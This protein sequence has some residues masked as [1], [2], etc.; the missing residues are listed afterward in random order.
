MSGL[1]ITLVGGSGNVTLNSNGTFDI[2]VTD[3][4]GNSTID[5]IFTDANGNSVTTTVSYPI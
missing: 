3:T 4:N 1:T 5:I 2:S